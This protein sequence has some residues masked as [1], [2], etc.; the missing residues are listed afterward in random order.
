MSGDEISIKIDHVSKKF[1]VHTGKNSTLKEKFLYSRREKW[2]DFQALQDISFEVPKGSTIGLLGANGSGKSTLLKLISRILYPDS[3]HIEV[4]GRVSSLLEL[5]AGFHP[6]FTGRE[7]IYLN[8]AMLGLSKRDVSERYEDILSFS[9]L[10][11][12]IDEPI[13]TYSSGMYMRLA[14]SV[15][16]AVDPDILLID[17]ILAVGDAAFQDK[18]MKYLRKL[19]LQNKTIVIV[20]HD[21]SAIE[22]FCHTAVWLDAGK[23]RMEGDAVSCVREYLRSSF[24]VDNGKEV[25]RLSYA[26]LQAKA[27]NSTD[28]EIT[29]TNFE[30]IL[31]TE[32][33]SIKGKR[34]LDINF[35]VK[36]NQSDLD[37]YF[38]IF[39]KS[40]T[41]ILV[42]EANTMN[43]LSTPIILVKGDNQR[44]TLHINDLP[45]SDGEYSI[46]MRAF[47]ESKRPVIDQK[48]MGVIQIA[49]EKK[50][51]M[52][53]LDVYYQWNFDKG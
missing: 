3:G 24:S 52:G 1:R 11:S 38:E 43:D 42:F 28:E 53:F 41:D 29:L 37:V 17:E 21:T 16:I 12:F 25:N 13:R 50:K 22:R 19:Q 18:C 8:G 39:I 23:M 30:A 5:G 14:F 32:G 49:I 51:S 40:E 46:Q 34:S 7:N 9:E 47:E 44:V 36:A 6:D 15:A 33:D 31:L 10:G 45:L 20:S 48:D 4:R 26:D 27:P 2:M 35:T